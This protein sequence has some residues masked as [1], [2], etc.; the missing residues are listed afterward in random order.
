MT[1]YFIEYEKRIQIHIFSN[2]FISD[3]MKN[4]FSYEFRKSQLC[5][6]LLI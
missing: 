3:I 4:R 1:L 6:A 2:K 5:S